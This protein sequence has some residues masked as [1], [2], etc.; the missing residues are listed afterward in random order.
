MS[1][2]DQNFRFDP[3]S[4]TDALVNCEAT[5]AGFVKETMKEA[6]RSGA[7]GFPHGQLDM[8]GWQFRP[9][10]NQAPKVDDE[11]TPEYPT[12][13]PTVRGEVTVVE[14]SEHLVL[15][16]TVDESSTPGASAPT[17]KPG[18]TKGIFDVRPRSHLIVFGDV[19]TI[20]G[21]IVVPGT[22]VVIF[23][24]RC[25]RSPLAIRRR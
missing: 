2:L 8:K 18:E 12:T 3:H 10:G 21:K 14:S 17:V 13:L 15:M 20:R 7:I 5:I 16:Q 23:G 25:G 6:G 11:M 4:F 19:V 1:I 24:A 22:H 9:A